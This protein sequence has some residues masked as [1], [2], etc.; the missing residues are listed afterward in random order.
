MSVSSPRRTRGVRRCCTDEV[1][2]DFPS[3]A[4]SSSQWD[5]RVTVREYYI[6]MQRA[7]KK[8]YSWSQNVLEAKMSP[9]LQVF[10][11]AEVVEALGR[12]GDLP[13]QQLSFHYSH[14]REPIEWDWLVFPYR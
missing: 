4:F 2:E 9:S 13:S 14:P 12:L 11:M 5:E 10:H 3:V 8:V 7:P 1:K 6:S